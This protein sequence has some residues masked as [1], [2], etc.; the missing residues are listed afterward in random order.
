MAVPKGKISKS[1]RGLRRGGNGSITAEL[2]NV[3]TNKDGEYV[4]PHHVSKDGSY[5][6]KKVLEAKAEEK[7]TDN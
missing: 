7:E 6:G 3:V 5:N 4:L 2:P 1:K